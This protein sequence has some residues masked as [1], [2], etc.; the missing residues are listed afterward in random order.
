[1]NINEL[2]KQIKL[3]LNEGL[4]ESANDEYVEIVNHTIDQAIAQLDKIKQRLQYRFI[5]NVSYT[6]NEARNV[7]I[8]LDRI[9]QNGVQDIFDSCY[10]KLG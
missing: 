5:D 4:N 6:G 9:I 10:N 1:M 8:E 3:C 7:A 2:D